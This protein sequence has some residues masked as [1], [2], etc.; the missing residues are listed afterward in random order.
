MDL[1]TFCSILLSI[2]AGVVTLSK[3][4]EIIRPLVKPETK[5]IPRIE[6]L[7]ADSKQH[8]DRIK[9]LEDDITQTKDFETVMSR[10]ILAQTNY[11]LSPDKEDTDELKHARDELNRFLTD[12][13]I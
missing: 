2:A 6:K 4:W 11:M 7:E 10:V 9:N 5:V 13:R 3:C 8:E 12:R 1:Q